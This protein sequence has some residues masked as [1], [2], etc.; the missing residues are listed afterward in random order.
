MQYRCRAGQSGCSLLWLREQRHFI[1]IRTT[2]GSAQVGPGTPLSN[3]RRPGR[4]GWPLAGRCLAA[5]WRRL[6]SCEL[7]TVDPLISGPLVGHCGQWIVATRM[8]LPEKLRLYRLHRLVVDAR[9]SLRTC[10]L[11]VRF[12]TSVLL[13]S[14]SPRPH[15]GLL[16][17]TGVA[18]WS[19]NCEHASTLEAVVRSSARSSRTPPVRHTMIYLP[20]HV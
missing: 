5:A 6:A 18:V 4:P 19:L 17:M 8:N 1:K 3:P 11:P 20:V 13:R 15:A 9:V 10:E 7:S 12:S 16:P 2:P 14:H